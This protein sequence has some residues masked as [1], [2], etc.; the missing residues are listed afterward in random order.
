MF[1]VIF[2]LIYSKSKKYDPTN[3]IPSC[4]LWK[5]IVK[6]YR[7]LS[8]YVLLL[9][10]VGTASNVV[11][12]QLSS[13]AKVSTIGALCFTAG[14]Y[15]PK[16]AGH[17]ATF[18]KMLLAQSSD[19]EIH[20]GF[21]KIEGH[22]SALSLFIPLRELF[23]DKKIKAIVLIADGSSYHYGAAAAF[24][25]V[26][27]TLKQSYPKPVF[28]YS[29]K[30][31]E[32]AVYLMACATDGIYASSKA[33]I[34][35][36][37][38]V[39]TFKRTHKKDMNDGIE[40]NFIYKGLFKAISCTHCPLEQEQ[41]AMIQHVVNRLHEQVIHQIKSARPVLEK[42]EQEWAD[43]K[44]F[45]AFEVCS[46][47]GLIDKV[48][49]KMEFI[50]SLFEHLKLPFNPT[51]IK[52]VIKQ[53]NTLPVT[54]LSLSI[55][56]N[57]RGIG[58]IRVGDL[59]KGSGWDYM[60]NLLELFA[61]PEICGIILAIDSNGGKS[62]LG[63]AL[64]DDIAQLKKVYSKPV[65][66]YIEEKAHSAGYLVACAADHII[67]SPNAFTGSIGTYWEFLNH[68]KK[69]CKEHVDYIAIKT[70]EY[71]NLA[72]TAIPFTEEKKQLIQT[73]VNVSHDEL[74]KTIKEARPTLTKGDDS[75]WRE[76]QYFV[77]HDALKIG[78]I[79]Q[80]GSY[81][82]AFDY[83]NSRIVSGKK[84]TFENVKFIIKN[85]TVS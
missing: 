29:E 18:K 40:C 5:A 35:D 72:N 8:F 36:I 53:A 26:L 9:L 41:Q 34:G 66:A 15:A 17:M 27:H 23:V 3:T 20:I 75:L 33:V 6:R 85:V 67:A 21:L 39:W 1:F 22:E 44:P 83:I 10:H 84:V 28:A 47:L 38:C 69:N 55:S 32:G 31:L 76:A 30:E 51:K 81:T 7:A 57:E 52:P 62:S 54:P 73:M 37:G 59:D 80:L 12:M 4:L 42:H 58:I 77:A 11:A 79:D 74:I 64:Y 43:G 2:F 65:V 56:V 78:L 70:G 48:A 61:R 50:K 24:I 71:I 45:F 25:R 63:A 14:L 19:E 46:R 13:I 82:E 49:S 60:S 68:T 16:I